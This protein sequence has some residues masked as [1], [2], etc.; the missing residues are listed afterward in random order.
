MS[1]ETIAEKLLLSADETAALL[2]IGRT[3]LWGLHSAG[4]IPLPVK[5]G[6]RTLWNVEE[7]RNWIAAG[8]P[9]REVW[10]QKK[11][12]KLKL[13]AQQGKWY[14]NRNIQAALI[15]AVA[16]ILVPIIGWFL[17]SHSNKQVFSLQK[18]VSTSLNAETRGNLSPIIVTSGPNSPVNIYI[19][20]SQ[21]KASSEVREMDVNRPK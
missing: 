1:V 21:L 20:P 5:L 12:E 19:S 3:L 10:E 9:H 18:N 8:T 15:K 17:N 11:K 13:Q 6:R 14:R 16:I 2:G 7:L 4:K